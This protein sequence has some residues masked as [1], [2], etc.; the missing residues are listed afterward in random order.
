MNLAD[1]L[2]RLED[3]HGRGAL[4]DAEYVR[5]KRRLLEPSCIEPVAAKVNALRRSRSDRW[6]AG[7]CGGLATA[8][9]MAPWACRLGFALLLVFGG[10]GLLLYLLLWL[11]VPP[12]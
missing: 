6:I 4:S 9:G 8:T 3:L 7:V 12:E 10:A 11:F 2:G 5:A 1:E